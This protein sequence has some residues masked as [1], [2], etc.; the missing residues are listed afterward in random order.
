MHKVQILPS[1][2]SANFANLVYDIS[3]VEKAGAKILH[4]DI[5]DGHFVPNITIGPVVIESIR[6]ITQCHLQSHLM[7]TN[8]DAYIDA[9]IDAGSDSIIIHY[10]AT[11]DPIKTLRKIRKKGK[12]AGIAL[13]PKTEVSCLK[14]I[15]NEL[16]LVLIMSVEPG[17]GGQAFIPES[18]TKIEMLSKLLK[19]TNRMIPIGVD[20]GI[21]SKTI[22]GVVRAGA[23]QLVAGNSV[24]KGDIEENFELLRGKIKN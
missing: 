3:A 21:N 16:D 22:E 12:L 6:K 1:L 24:F 20:G 19:D 7:I 17:F 2:L 23:T 9:F 15:I 8:P 10:E 14:E 4:L 18:V 11:N 5:M 13:K